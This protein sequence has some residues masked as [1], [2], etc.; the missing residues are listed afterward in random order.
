MEMI[1]VLV[2]T[3][4]YTYK[5]D[6]QREALLRR[7]LH[8]DYAKTMDE[9]ICMLMDID[10]VLV[11]IRAETVD[12]LPMLKVMHKIK[13][14]PILVFSYAEGTDKG[15]ALQMGANIYITSPY[16]RDYIIES[17]YALAQLYVNSNGRYE[18]EQPTFL[19]YEYV[20]VCVDSR[21][22]FVKGKLLDLRKKEFD[23]LCLLMQNQGKVL[24]YTEIFRQVWGEEYIDS[25]VN[26]LSSVIYRIKKTLMKIEPS[27][28]NYIK[29][30]HH[31]GYSFTPN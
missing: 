29:N 21:Q 24:H 12:Y 7:N 6:I 27:T 13:P 9:A 18:T 8:M 25:S 10:Y 2:V 22:V 26:T 4:D 23:V 1:Y 15:N 16:S 14:I 3:G 31:S 11:V 5:D 30:K 17:A 20:R 19:T 28:K